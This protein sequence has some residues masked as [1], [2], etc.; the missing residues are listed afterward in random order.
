MDRYTGKHSVGKFGPINTTER[1]IMS[2]GTQ[3]HPEDEVARCRRVR[4][5]LSRQF[6]TVDEMCDFLEK[7][8]SQ[9]SHASVSAK[10]RSGI[11]GKKPKKTPVRNGAR[12]STRAS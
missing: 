7:W 8:E 4:E 1:V 12:A 3:P 5:E 2:N 10:K 11:H 6:K 9:H